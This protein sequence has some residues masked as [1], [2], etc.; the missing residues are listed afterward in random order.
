M[1]L[2][3]LLIN[4][5]LSKTDFESPLGLLYIEQAIRGAG[6][7]VK[8][9]DLVFEYDLEYLTAYV[10]A[11]KC[12]VAGIYA[13]SP[14][15]TN[16]YLA[17]LIIKRAYPKARTVFGGPHPTLFPKEV[18]QNECVDFIVQGEGEETIV[19]LLRRIEEGQ[20]VFGDIEGIA[21]KKHGEIVVN[22]RRKLIANLDGLPFPDRGALATREGYMNL[23]G[24][25]VIFGM[26]T[27]N[28]IASRGCCFT[29]AFCQ[30]ALD[31]IHGGKVRFRGV[32]NVIAEMDDLRRNW[33][34]Q[35]IWFEDDIFTLN[36]DWLMKFCQAARKSLPG[37][38]W[39]C[40]SRLDVVDEEMLLNMRQAGCLQIRY[41][42]E[43]GDQQVLDSDFKKGIN[44]SRVGS[45]FEMTRSAGIKTYA[46]V[47]IGGKHESV[48]SVEATKRF[49]REVHPD[50]V[51]L[52]ITTPMPG[53][54]LKEE[55]ELDNTIIFKSREYKDIK[56]FERCNFD[57][58]NLKAAEVEELY[59]GIFNAV[60]FFKLSSPF[61]RKLIS[62]IAMNLRFT[63]FLIFSKPKGRIQLA[64]RLMA[65]DMLLVF[66][67]AILHI[68]GLN[69]ID[70][71]F[72]N[73][74]LSFPYLA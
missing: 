52:A 49:L 22:P 51:Q 9:V 66:R 67:L 35:A 57:T 70:K 23:A 21:F 65:A 27:L 16:A 24:I 48:A 37:I 3:I 8:V 55:M 61:N 59:R 53:T 34:I 15:I 58:P 60:H 31:I 72:F 25:K 41:G 18:L 17:A 54:R 62:W 12:D 56:L 32:N 30:P 46:Y 10:E 6:H 43:S 7:R 50:H 74:R 13:M 45:V 69:K 20:K 1:S 40:N 29:C 28:L 42:L 4:P 11:N 44:L 5:S 33:K 19:E 71:L 64:L 39:S 14:M 2:N 36:R 26:R 47:M 68:P 38:F 73:K 63:A